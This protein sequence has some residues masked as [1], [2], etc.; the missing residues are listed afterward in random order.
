ME[1]RI[2]WRHLGAWGTICNI[3][4]DMN[5]AKVA[6]RNLGFSK[7]VATKV[8]YDLKK[9]SSDINPIVSGFR[10]QGNEA[11]LGLCGY[12]ALSSGTHRCTRDN[13]V[14]IVCGGPS[15]LGCELF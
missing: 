11:V 12:Y 15:K 3:G 7:V 14:T 9:T 6:C 4:W 8:S 2:E 1:G 10:C 5:A 13:D